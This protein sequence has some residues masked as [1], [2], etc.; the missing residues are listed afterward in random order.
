MRKWNHILARIILILFLLHALM[1]SLILLGFSTISFFP[2]SWFLLAVVIIHGILG[3][4]STFP[5]VRTGWKTGH[6]YFKQNLTFWIKRISGLSVLLLLI[7]HVTAYT[8]SVNGRFFLRE[9]TR[10]RM[11]LQI[12][13]ILSIFIHLAVSIKPMLITKGTVKFKERTMDWMLILSTM[14][15]FFTVAVILYYIKWQM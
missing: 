14:M 12:F 15:L 1:G 7:F 3:L 10:C 2:L 4:L 5:A 13:F 9:F 11:V 8:T 6:W